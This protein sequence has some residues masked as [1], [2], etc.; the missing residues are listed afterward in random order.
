MFYVTNYFKKSL[1][2][3]IICS[4]KLFILIDKYLMQ[5]LTNKSLYKK[6]AFYLL[7]T[8]KCILL[9]YINR[10]WVWKNSILYKK[11]KT[12]Y[13]NHLAWIGD[14]EKSEYKM[15]A[16]TPKWVNPILNIIGVNTLRPLNMVTIRFWVESFTLKKTLNRISSY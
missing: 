16:S 9:S 6:I 7:K 11:N 15:E 13:N 2:I 12:S 8:I 4:G 10:K 3:A 1:N 14:T 5:I